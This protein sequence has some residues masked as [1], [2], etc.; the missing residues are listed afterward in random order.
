MKKKMVMMAVIFG[1]LSVSGTMH[2]Q[3][4]KD[5]LNSSTVKEVVNAVTGGKNV[6]FEALQGTW[7]Y[8][9]P[10]CELESSNV[11]KEVGGS[12]ITS[13]IEKKL[14]EMCT[15]VGIKPGVFNFTF[16]SDSTFTNTMVKGSLNGTYSYD[17]ETK[18]VILHYA[19][20]KKLTVTT[21]EAKAEMADNKLTLL[22]NADKLMKLLS[23]ASSMTNNS[24]L[25]TINSLASQY[26]G[27]L[28]GFD[29]NK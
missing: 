1:L 13:Q 29:L 5:F 8:Q 21:L 14:G 15:K 9:S 28:L 24:T 23:Y 17:P 4:L 27:M 7:T 18:M 10:A 22:F 11:L 3:S 12:A 6:T 20:G 25:K 26:D 2:G 19:A 16:N